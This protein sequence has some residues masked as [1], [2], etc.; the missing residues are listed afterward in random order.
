MINYGVNR[1]DNQT[2]ES[3]MNEHC[4]DCCIGPQGPTGPK[5]DTGPQG[6]KGPIG[7]TGRTPEI[8][9][10]EVN[11]SL[12]GGDATVNEVPTM[13][14]VQLNFTLPRG[15]TGP[16]GSQGATG[17]RG[18]S[19]P[20]GVTGAR[21][22]TGADGIA[23]ATGPK[24]AT[25]ATGITGNTGPIGPTGMTGADG[26]TGPTGAIPIVRVGSTTTTSPGENAWVDSV[27]IQDGIEL[28]FKLPKGN[29]GPTGAIGATGIQGPTGFEGPAGPTG[30]TGMTGA[31]GATGAIPLITV[32]TTTTLEPNQPAQVDLKPI[33]QGVQ[34]DF[35]IP[36][37]ATGALPQQAFASYY[38]FQGYFTDG[39]QIP[40]L[41][42]VV[43]TTGNIV[44]DNSSLLLTPGYYLINYNV[45][46]I[47][48][49]PG[50]MQIT[51]FYDGKVHLELGVYVKTTQNQQT[52]M[53][54]GSLIAYIT[55]TS[56]FSLTYNSNVNSTEGTLTLTV[57]KLNR[58]S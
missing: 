18:P 48:A 52:A 37:G 3:W 49:T 57:L 26:A 42:S 40:L 58:T 21:G 31:T 38:V 28:N 11:T 45:T 27:P 20:R 33:E 16:T 25:G 22:N 50:Y 32:G 29:T 14:G 43:D 6:V 54:S 1:M 8:T 36:K 56:R 23:G 24:G 30:N 53:G 41:E 39:I 35:S 7:R 51:P 10:G 12:P 47:L 15:D 46:V 34:L 4:C 13:N 19:G 9:I 17:L 44:Q 5:G 2:E 55:S